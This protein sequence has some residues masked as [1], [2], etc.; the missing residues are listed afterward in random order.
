[1][2]Y[3]DRALILAVGPFREIDIWV[4]LFSQKKGLITAFAFG[5][6]RSRRRFA[7]CLLPFGHVLLNIQVKSG[8]T[9]LLEGLL[10]SAHPNLRKDL[11]RLGM[12]ANCL[13][14]FETVPIAAEGIG[15]AYKLLLGALDFLEHSPQVYSL[16]PTFFRLKVAFEE[17][18]SPAMDV[19][20][21]C[22]KELGTDLSIVDVEK[23]QFFCHRCRQIKNPLKLSP[24][25]LDILRHIQD[26]PLTQDADPEKQVQWSLWP[27]EPKS[28]RVRSECAE[29][30]ERFVRHH[31]GIGWEGNRFRRL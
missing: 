3:S 20:I 26:L 27:A 14:F 30:I 6:A 18:Y 8:Y 17:G 11:S 23:G 10:L 24:E 15:A 2:E 16:F 29:F 13:K 22:G 9:T 21:N 7:G 5:G 28:I 12:A 1:M 31:L 25:S 4:R 19:C